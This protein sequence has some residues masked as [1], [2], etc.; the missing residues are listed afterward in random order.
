VI[1]FGC[2]FGEML[3][4]WGEAFGIGGVGIDI[5][6]YACERARSKM[7]ARGLSDRIE[8]VC[9]HAAS[10]DFTPETYEVATCIGASFVWDGFRGAVR[11]LG[12]TLRPGGRLVVGEPYWRRA[13]EPPRYAQ[14]QAAVHTETELLQMARAEG[15]EV[16]YVL[17][18]SRDEWDRYVSENWRGLLRWLQEHPEHPERQ[19]V[20]DH[21]HESQ[22]E[23]LR[24]GREYFGWAL[25]ALWPA[26]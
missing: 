26:T 16:A 22:E 13:L 21:L 5:R 23:Y 19:D 1:D 11:H 2:G 10:Y 15:Y 25:Y 8:I 7:A 12:Q 24:Y 9:E 6:P 14:E 17:H 20:V 18:S 3:A 4:L